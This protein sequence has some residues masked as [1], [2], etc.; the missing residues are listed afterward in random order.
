MHSPCYLLPPVVLCRELLQFVLELLLLLQGRG[1]V[2][3]QVVQ[4]PKE[5]VDALLDLWA[6]MVN[7]RGSHFKC[8]LICMLAACMEQTAPA[9]M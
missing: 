1:L 5:V 3:L 6:D 2:L 4:L 7:S 8:L 9:S